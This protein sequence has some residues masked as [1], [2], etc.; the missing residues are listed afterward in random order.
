MQKFFWELQLTATKVLMN[1]WRIFVQL[2]I[3]NY[4]LFYVFSNIQALKA[5]YTYEVIHCLPIQLL[6]FDLEDT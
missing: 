3:I 1:M 2:P 6:A 5:S 4:V